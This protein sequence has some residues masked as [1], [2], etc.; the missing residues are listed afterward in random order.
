MTP[1]A[2]ST[3]S[4]LIALSAPFV[5]LVG[6]HYLWRHSYYGAWLPN[7][8]YAKVGAEQQWWSMGW[9]YAAAFVLEYGYYL[10]LPVVV[11]IWPFLPSPLTRRLGLLFAACILCHAGYYCYKVGGDHF[12]FRVFDFYVPLISWAIAESVVF[13]YGRHKVSALA[14]GV[15]ALVSSLVIPVSAAVQGRDVHALDL[16]QPQAQAEIILG[17][18][19]AAAWVPGLASISRWH[20]ALFKELNAHL[21]A[22]RWEVHRA[23]WQ[24]RMR[25]VSPLRQ[26][27]ERGRLP[28]MTIADGSPGILGYYVDLPIVDLLGLTD[29]EVARRG[30]RTSQGLIAH[31]LRP[32]PGYLQERGVNAILLGTGDRPHPRGDPL[33]WGAFLGL[34]GSVAKLYSI[35]IAKRQWLHIVAWDDAWLAATFDRTA[36]D[37]VLRHPASE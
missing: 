16:L 14:F 7:T 31:Q 19:P 21:I 3:L 15:T 36:S 4:E 23:F 35:Q 10:T 22:S 1:A 5:L 9:R 29:A 37:L 25:W 6:A 17:S 2:G 33:P 8:Y 30:A 26:L 11:M 28:V 32:P 12:E 34:Q 18:I 24:A 27:V 20:H 13:W